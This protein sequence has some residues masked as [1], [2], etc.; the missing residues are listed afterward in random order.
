[1]QIGDL[2][3]DWRR[4]NVSFTRAKRKLVIFG[5]RSTLRSDPLLGDF[6]NLMSEKGWIY[7]LPPKGDQ[8][9]M[10]KESQAKPLVKAEV[11]DSG[12]QRVK[13]SRLGE[14]I[15]KDRPFLRDILGVSPLSYGDHVSADKLYQND[16]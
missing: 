11:I 4:I 16:A 13:A 12:V 10:G 2:L 7:T 14:T 1:M 6:L 9:H 3:K 15:L 5:S 8:L